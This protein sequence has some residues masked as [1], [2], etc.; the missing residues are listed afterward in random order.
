MD[1]AFGVLAEKTPDE[2]ASRYGVGAGPGS[3]P[4]FH[5]TPQGS[6]SS[7]S[8]ARSGRIETPARE[9]QNGRA[10]SDEC[11]IG[12]AANGCP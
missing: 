9:D 4:R 8:S 7:K 10:V 2:V 6:R 3:L 11:R 12:C 1:S 5:R